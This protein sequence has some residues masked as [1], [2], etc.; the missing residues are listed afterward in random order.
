[1]TNIA[2]TSTTG[3]GFLETDFDQ[4]K[5]L[6]QDGGVEAVVFKVLDNFKQVVLQQV[7][8][9]LLQCLMLMLTLVI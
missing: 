7:Q 3:S 1:M 8:H 9:V 4:I 5:D 2:L 6:I